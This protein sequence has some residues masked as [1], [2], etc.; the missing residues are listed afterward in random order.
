MP[1]YQISHSLTHASMPVYRITHRTT[2]RHSAPVMA[3]W[4]VL[5]L[6][7]RAERNQ[8]CLEF[9]LEVSPKPI[10]LDA[11]LDFFGNTLHLFSLR[12]PHRELVIQSTSLVRRGEPPI[13]MPGLTPT[14]EG[15]RELVEAA[16]EGGEFELEQFRFGSPLVPRL[17]EV[18]AFTQG[19][20]DDDPPIL[21]WMSRLGARFKEQ[22]AFDPTATA[23]STPLADF[24]SSKRGVCQ[25]FAHLYIACARALGIPAAYVSGYLLTQP[26]PGQERMAGAD[27]SH[28]WVSLYVP[29]TGWI[30]Y[31]PT[32]HIFVGSQHVVVARGRDYADIA[33]TRGIFSGGGSHVLLIGVTMELADDPLPGGNP[34]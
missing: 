15:C 32:N 27:A 8:E 10:D 30:D 9:D 31:D 4:Q 34:R 14:L 6:H 13:P 29:G 23:V 18:L 21:T 2:F 1:V 11:R 3:A 25:D 16:V 28:A 7:P 12:E 33:P 26:P 20:S 24:L 5:H 17:P 22:L 19:L